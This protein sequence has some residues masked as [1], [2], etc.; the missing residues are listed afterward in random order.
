[1]LCKK[2]TLMVVK[3]EASA[4][5]D[6]DSEKGGGLVVVLPR[7]VEGLRDVGGMERGT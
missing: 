3:G 1:M 7:A 6:G 5:G 2:M 4:G